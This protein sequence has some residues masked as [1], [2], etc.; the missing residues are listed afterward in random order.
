MAPDDDRARLRTLLAK[1]RRQA[2]WN[3]LWALI[4]ALQLLQEH[5]GERR[6]QLARAREACRA[7]R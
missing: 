5:L 4:V 3:R 1:A 2:G 7:A 6:R